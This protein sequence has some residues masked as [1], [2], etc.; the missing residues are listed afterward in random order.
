MNDDPLIKLLVLLQQC[1]STE[2]SNISYI[3]RNILRTI[4][5][6]SPYVTSPILLAERIADVVKQHDVQ[7]LRSIG[8][9]DAFSQGQCDSK[10]WLCNELAGITTDLGR[11]FVL[12]GW[13]GT[14][15]LLLKNHNKNF[16]IDMIRSFDIDTTCAVLAETLNRPY[17]KDNWMFKAFTKD[18]NELDYDAFEWSVW[19]TVNNRMSYPITDSAD[20]IINTSC[21]HMGSNNAWWDKIPPGRLV[22]LQNNDWF[23]NDQHNNSAADLNEFTRMY[24]MSELLF[25]GELDCT[26]YTRFMLI[27]RK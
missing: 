21:D 1:A 8:V 22:I 18:I 16:N 6:W 15:P 20:T 10:S 2:D 23:E 12:C 7:H 26:L 3:D 13:I 24:H 9:M 17:V 11:V 4:E 19:S 25:A 27:G 5:R 14:L